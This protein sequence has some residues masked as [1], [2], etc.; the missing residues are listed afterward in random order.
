MLRPLAWVIC[1]IAIAPVLQAAHWPS[2]RGPDGNGISP[3]KQFPTEWTASRNV[4][5]RV[6]LPDD[7]NSS[8]IVW[9]DRVFITQA[10]SSENRRMVMCFDRANGKLLWQSGTVHTE[11][12]PTHETNP[13]CAASPVTDGERVIATF[14]SAGVFC[15]D[16]NGKELWRRDLG[17]QIH[18]WGNASSPVLHGNACLLYHGPG[19]TSF[20][21]ALDKKTGRTL[22]QVDLPEPKPTKRTDGFAG[23][24]PGIIGTWS[25]PQVIHVNG[26]DE[27]LLSV[28]QSVRAFDPATGRELW[29]CGGINELVYTSTIYGEGLVVAMGGFFGSTVAVKPGG[30]G[31][32][33]GTHVVWREERSKKNRLGSGVISAGHIFVLNMD[34]IAQCLNLKTGEMVWEER[35]KGAGAKG[36]SWSSL[37]MSGDRIYAVNQSGDVFVLKASPQFELLAVNSTGEP[38]NSTLAL[39]NGE[40]FLRTHKGLW[41]ISQAKT[42]ASLR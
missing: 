17:K 25:T 31:D 37:V 30:T 5:W 7:G 38:T 10:I 4:R 9:G 26:R 42:T 21:I 8:P 27:C 15:F 32:V 34:G 14:G 11:K 22:W 16:L 35:L 6:D 29:K 41:C 13:Y 3:E 18:Q 24:E 33:T 28:P 1:A 36:D 12:E 2:W 20:L 19:E 39:S 23:K 40:I